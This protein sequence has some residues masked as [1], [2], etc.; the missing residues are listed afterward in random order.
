MKARQSYK[1]HMSLVHQRD[2]F[3][4]RNMGYQTKHSDFTAKE[5]ERVDRD[6]NLSQGL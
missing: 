1:K 6:S 4:A 2:Q 3:Y 5:Y